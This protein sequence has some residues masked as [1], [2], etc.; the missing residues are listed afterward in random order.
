MSQSQIRPSRSRQPSL[1]NVS[2]TAGQALAAA[3]NPSSHNRSPV[4]PQPT[5]TQKLRTPIGATT[6]I[7][8]QRRSSFANVGDIASDFSTSLG[9]PYTYSISSTN[10]QTSGSP[11]NCST[12][13]FNTNSFLPS[14]SSLASAT[15]NS[16]ISTRTP[17]LRTVLPQSSKGSSR[18]SPRG[19]INYLDIS[20]N[21][22]QRRYSESSS[23][24]PSTEEVF[25]LMER[26]QDA[27]VLKLM[28]EISQLREENRALLSTINT[29][30]SSSSFGS[31]PGSKRTSV[32]GRA[33]SESPGKAA[34]VA[35]LYSSNH[36]N[37]GNSSKYTHCS[38]LQGPLDDSPYSHHYHNHNNHHHRH[39]HHRQSSVSE[40]ESKV[41][42]ITRTFDP[43]LSVGLDVS[44]MKLEDTSSL[45]LTGENISIL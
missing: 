41:P 17:I 19:S 25:D 2:S 33:S 16:T 12:T 7:S 40:R 45:D 44:S 8:G 5:S 15:S 20:A 34:S 36:Y 21:E 30:Q 4:R 31:L 23:R 43:E 38:V 28:R 39:H 3:T 24:R 35:T 10:N 42:R 1:S 32:S 14:S 11:T 26:E 18:S 6:S 27:I 29:M 22:S 9:M 37:Q 13:S